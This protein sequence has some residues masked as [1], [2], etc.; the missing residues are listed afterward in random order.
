ML[1]GPDHVPYGGLKS[2]HVLKMTFFEPNYLA[3]ALSFRSRLVIGLHI[4]QTSAALCAQNGIDLLHFL[5]NVPPYR[6]QAPITADYINCQG[7]RTSSALNNLQ[8]KFYLVDELASIPLRVSQIVTPAPDQVIVSANDVLVKKALGKITQYFQGSSRGSTS[9]LSATLHSST[10]ESISSDTL[11]DIVS[12]YAHTGFAQFRCFEHDFLDNPIGYLAVCAMTDSREEKITAI[13]KIT[14]GL[15][16]ILQGAVSGMSDND[17]CLALLVIDFHPSDRSSQYIDPGLHNELTRYR[18]KPL[19]LNLQL[20]QQY[21]MDP[22]TDVNITKYLQNTHT[23]RCFE[24]LFSCES[25]AADIYNDINWSPTSFDPSSGS[26]KGL[27]ARPTISDLTIKQ[28][29]VL[30]SFFNTAFAYYLRTILVPFLASKLFNLSESCEETVSM[31][32]KMANILSGHHTSAKQSTR[33]APAHAHLSQG[34]AFYTKFSIEYRIRRLADLLLQCNLLDDACAYYETLLPKQKHKAT[35]PFVAEAYEGAS[36]AILRRYFINYSFDNAHIHLSTDDTSKLLRY[37]GEALRI[38]NDCLSDPALGHVSLCNASLHSPFRL[39]GQV[40]NSPLQ[41]VENG[42]SPFTP[43]PAFQTRIS[44]YRLFDYKRYLEVTAALVYTVTGQSFHLVEKTFSYAIPHTIS[45]ITAALSYLVSS[46]L[47]CEARYVRMGSEAA[48]KAGAL[49]FNDRLF[50]LAFL[51]FTYAF[52]NLDRPNLLP[53]LKTGWWFATIYESEL[54]YCSTRALRSERLD[55]QLGAPKDPTLIDTLSNKIL[56]LLKNTT[57][58]QMHS[59]F[60]YPKDISSIVKH[61]PST[62][63]DP[64]TPIGSCFASLQRLLIT[65]QVAIPQLM[66]LFCLP[67]STAKEIEERSLR[68][69]IKNVTPP[70]RNIGE[71]PLQYTVRLFSDLIQSTSGDADSTINAF[72]KKAF[73]P[74][75]KFIVR[76]YLVDFLTHIVPRLTALDYKVFLNADAE[77]LKAIHKEIRIPSVSISGLY[78]PNVNLASLI[79]L[80]DQSLPCPFETLQGLVY[81][82]LVKTQMLDQLNNI[83]AIR[84]GETAMAIFCL[85][86]EY[87]LLDYDIKKM[88]LSLYFYDESNRPLPSTTLELKSKNALVIPTKMVFISGSILLCGIPIIMPSDTRSVSKMEIRGLRISFLPIDVRSGGSLSKS[89]SFSKSKSSLPTLTT[90]TVPNDGTTVQQ[91]DIILETPVSFPVLSHAADIVISIVFP[92]SPVLPGQIIRGQLMVKNTGQREV[93]NLFISSSYQAYCVYDHEA[94]IYLDEIPL[95]SSRRASTLSTGLADVSLETALSFIFSSPFVVLSELE[96]IAAV[97]HDQSILKLDLAKPYIKKVLQNCMRELTMPAM[98]QDRIVVCRKGLRSHESIEIPVLFLIPPGTPP[99]KILVEYYLGYSINIWPVVSEAAAELH[100]L[101]ASKLSL[102]GQPGLALPNNETIKSTAEKQYRVKAILPSAQ[103]ELTAV[104]LSKQCVPP[105]LCKLNLEKNGFVYT[106]TFLCDQYKNSLR[107]LQQRSTSFTLTQ[108][109]KVGIPPAALTKE[110]LLVQS[111]EITG[112]S[113]SSLLTLHN[114]LTALFKRTELHKYGASLLS[115]AYNYLKKQSNFSFQDRNDTAYNLNEL[116]ST[117]MKDL[118]TVQNAV[119]DMYMKEFCQTTMTDFSLIYT[120]GDKVF[121]NREFAV[122]AS[123]DPPGLGSISAI[124]QCNSATDGKISFN[125]IMVNRS[126]TTIN[127]HV[128][129]NV[130][131]PT[132]LFSMVGLQ[133]IIGEI[134][135]FEVTA[136]PFMAC[137]SAVGECTIS[138]A[139]DATVSVGSLSKKVPVVDCG[140]RL[141]IIVA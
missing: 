95:E 44:V 28:S 72:L 101:S 140:L 74:A 1:R 27:Y 31:G 21:V 51:C 138:V 55:I 107:S 17:V 78:H 105:S 118:Q 50:N 6:V 58:K 36:I 59:E 124:V 76:D 56:Q 13:K 128:S 45:S 70:V 14:T 73:T 54:L 106:G 71:T 52:M 83:K 65:N 15:P 63:S 81:H 39:P 116:H 16:A 91:T 41:N 24:Y 100:V 103:D 30:F 33:A 62:F 61:A 66:S 48:F 82:K 46:F 88:E 25:T 4:N 57:L 94:C 26:T 130:S 3:E 112:I 104:I 22:S 64:S 12:A 113:R 47:L 49:F 90:S 92:N 97:P 133:T 115:L 69:C 110:T 86:N 89:S 98:L 79:L 40:F 137:A 127:T 111:K 43:T 38:I 96:Q 68:F 132:G 8:F 120:S 139:V 18:V 19:Y 11:R 75:R 53:A 20:F 2:S 85:S 34:K 42:L 80:N 67:F 121:L 141:S 5:R 125:L 93:S 35:S 77:K 108:Q 131:G 29:N 32:K 114:N 129:A 123:R 135:S 10:V 7:R 119:L 60:F 109:N 134:R 117:I 136:I 87:P 9:S 23:K 37:Y 102:Q 84:A 126:L 99:G 122:P